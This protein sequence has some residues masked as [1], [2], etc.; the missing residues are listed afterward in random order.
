MAPFDQE[1]Y[2]LIS[3][4]VGGTHGYYPDI[5]NNFYHNKSNPRPWPNIHPR[6]VTALKEK[7]VR[8]F[9]EKKDDW[10]KTWVGDDVDF[11]IDYVRVHAN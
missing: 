9:W 3:L 4:K 7:P 2:I 6:L 5:A 8:M 10:Y 11:L 1:F